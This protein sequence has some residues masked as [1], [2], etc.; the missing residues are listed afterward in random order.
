MAAELDGDADMALLLTAFKDLAAALHP[1]C[2]LACAEALP[3]VLTHATSR[4]CPRSCT[5]S[6]FTHVSIAAL[7][8]SSSS[9]AK[10]IQLWQGHVAVGKGAQ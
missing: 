1:H 3:A 6:S 7:C 5:L 9:P 8:C 2:R 10:E 4:R